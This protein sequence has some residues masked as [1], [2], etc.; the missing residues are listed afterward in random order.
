MQTALAARTSEVQ[1]AKD[2][3]SP[4]IAKALQARTAGLTIAQAEAA[5]KMARIDKIRDS[6]NAE[7]NEWLR[8]QLHDLDHG[9]EKSL[10]ENKAANINREQEIE[11]RYRDRKTE[12]EARWGEG[13]RQIQAP[14]DIDGQGVPVAHDWND[15]SWDTWMPSRRFASRVRFAEMQVDLKQIA[16][17]VPQKLN[18][19]ATF[20]L[21]AV[22][23]FPA[24]ASLL[25]HSD[26]AGRPEA[27]RTLQMVMARLLTSLPAGRVRFTII[28]PVG[29]GQNFAG[30]MHLSD[31]DDALVGGRIWTSQD[32]IDQKL[33]QP[34]RAHGN[35]HP[36][37][38][39]K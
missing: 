7:T 3:V 10:K 17:N 11:R 20:P 4:I 36:E 8:R 31:Y 22:L 38:S 12:L 14:I 18:L 19:P 32:Q 24:Q 37:I 28:D 16:E 27:I 29:L 2:Q 21:P 23:A 39:A 34:G 25:I 13:L 15:K 1:S 5:Q 30:F 33:D 6:A 26:Q 9:K 35:G